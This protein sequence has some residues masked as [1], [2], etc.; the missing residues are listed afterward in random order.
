MNT[1]I[2][3]FLLA[4]L[5]VALV[6]TAT[7]EGAADSKRLTRI[8]HIHGLAVDPA[9]ADHLLLATQRGF[10]RLAPDGLATLLS[11]GG[12]EFTG[13]AAATGNRRLFASGKVYRGKEK[14]GIQRSDDAGASWRKIADGA[15]GPVAFRR[16][17][18]SPSDPRLLYG[19][20]LNLQVS[21]DG[22]ATWAVVGPAPKSVL[23]MALAAGDEAVLYIASPRGLLGSSDGGKAWT[24]AYGGDSKKKIVATL[25]TTTLEGRVFS[26]IRKQGL[27]VRQ[28]AGAWRRLVA[29]KAFDGMLMRLVVDPRNAKHLFVVSQYMKIFESRDGGKTWS[30]YGL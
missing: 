1:R 15:A 17:A 12:R 29:A 9:A 23:G 5:A 3:P 30:R 22:G 7:A 2:R 28:G 18:V 10:Y 13:F 26:Y 16:M 8:T 21:R 14:L 19:L 20:G 6:A 24:P 25:I 4:L 11:A 27:V